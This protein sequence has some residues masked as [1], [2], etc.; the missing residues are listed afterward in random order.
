[1]LRVADLPGVVWRSLDGAD[2]RRHHPCL[3][4]DD[5]RHLTPGVRQP[6]PYTG[7]VGALW[8]GLNNVILCKHR[9]CFRSF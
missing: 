5:M 7:R 1:M 9:D 8:V 2:W 3:S 4:I 6:A